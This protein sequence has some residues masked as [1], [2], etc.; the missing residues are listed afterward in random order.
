[1]RF[2]TDT[3]TE[4]TEEKKPTYD[5][6]VDVARPN[7]AEEDTP[8]QKKRA[9]A[10]AKAHMEQEEF[11]VDD[12][13]DVQTGWVAS[14]AVENPGKDEREHGVLRC[15]ARSIEEAYGGFYLD[16]MEAYPVEQGWKPPSIVVDPEP[17]FAV[18]TDDGDGDGDGDSNTDD[19][20]LG[21]D[22]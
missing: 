14:F 19:D 21:E 11:G 4:K 20:T 6:G 15:I 9:K 12:L 3:V 18:A 5:M 13:A 7:T 1:M 8:E 17:F 22:Q 2:D 16:L 10:D